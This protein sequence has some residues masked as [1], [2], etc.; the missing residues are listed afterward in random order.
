MDKIEINSNLVKRLISSSLIIGIILGIVF[1]L[2]KWVFALFIT[3]MVGLGLLEFFNL[4]ELT[5]IK[6]YRYFGTVFGVIVPIFTTIFLEMNKIA[7]NLEP[8]LI[9]IVALFIFILQFERKDNQEALTRIAITVFGILY[10]SW[11][12]SF[13]INIMYFENGRS[14]VLFILFVTKMGDVGAYF[15]GSFFGKHSLIKHISP[16][17]SIEG[18]FGGILFSIITALISSFCLPGINSWHLFVLGLLIGGIGQLGDLSESLIK[19][20][21]QVKD[22]SAIFPGLG[23]ILDVADSLLFTI[24]IFYFYLVIFYFRS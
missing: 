12:P 24:P 10:I 2:P 13:L 8:F 5:N 7:S 3:I 19:R 1:F 6:V 4:V 21:C 22:S 20:G 11:F 23:G 17:K 15:I 9:V 14:L 18:T 16:K